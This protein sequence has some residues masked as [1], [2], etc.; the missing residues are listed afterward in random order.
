MEACVTSRVLVEYQL[1]TIYFTD[2]YVSGGKEDEAAGRARVKL[3]RISHVHI[4]TVP[5]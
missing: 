5:E 1:N 4:N 3:I 2:F